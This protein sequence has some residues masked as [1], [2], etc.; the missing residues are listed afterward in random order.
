MMIMHIRIHPFVS[1]EI[2]TNGG[3]G[4]VA[5]AGTYL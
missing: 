2:W 1:R 4:K 3:G 5:G